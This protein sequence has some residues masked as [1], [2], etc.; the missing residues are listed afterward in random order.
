M[1]RG[2][3]PL[4]EPWQYIAVDLIDP[5]ST[6]ESTLVVVDYY[7]R[8]YEVVVMYST[9]AERVMDALTQ[10]FSRYGYPFTL[11]SGN[12]S[13]FRCKELPMFL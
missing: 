1:K 6:G 11:K 7:S 5:F 3:N 2:V 4:P 10:V 12:C 9:T 13:R 8:F